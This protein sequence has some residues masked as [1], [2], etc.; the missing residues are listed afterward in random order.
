MSSELVARAVLHRIADAQPEI[1]L[2]DGAAVVTESVAIRA[3]EDFAE[4]AFSDIETLRA[5][6]EALE[7][8]NASL[9]KKLS[10]CQWYW[11]EDDTSS[12]ACADSAQEV[13]QNIYDWNHPEIPSVVA[14]ARGGIVEVTYCA[15]LPPADDADSDDDFWI[16]A[17]TEEAA[18]A[19]LDAE[20]ARR[21]REGGNADG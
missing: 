13:V 6:L 5:S 18:Q 4:R 14:V 10:G 17:E 1:T 9:R 15:A 21:A 11:P 12:E 8:E 16:E 2:E 19:M 20:I 3:M 7:A